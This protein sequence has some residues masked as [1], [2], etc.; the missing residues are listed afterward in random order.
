MTVERTPSETLP[1]PN[2]G[3]AAQPEAKSAA[4]A[5][6]PVLRHR[7]RVVLGW[8][9][10][11]LSG[12][13]V[14]SWLL[15]PA[16]WNI[17]SSHAVV[18]ARIM[19]LHSPIEGTIEAPPPAVGKAVEAGSVLVEIHN[20]LV[21]NSR[22]EELKTEA[23]SLDERVAALKRQ[24]AVLGSLK[25]SLADS[26][27]RYQ[28]AA[29]RRLETQIAEAKSTAAAAEA[30]L[31]QRRYKKDQMTGLLGDKGATQAEVVTARL[32]AEAAQN[33]VDQANLT[34]R[35]LS[36]QLE[37]VRQGNYIGSGDG[38]NDVPYSMQRMHEVDIHQQ[39]IQAKIQEF[40]ARA[41]QVQK[42]LRIE[43]ERLERQG[44]CRLKAPLDGIVW[45]RPLA[46]GST[47][48]RQTP[49]LELLDASDI[50]VD[51]L[52]GEKYFG[53]IHP[54]DKVA[55]KLIGSHAEVAGTVRDVLGKVAL[56][57]DRT[58]AAEAPKLG[59][60]DIHVIVSF[61]EGPPRSDNFHPYHIGQ[62]VEVRFTSSAGF[63]RQLWDL[64]S[65]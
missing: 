52:V 39:E 49:V 20:P 46:G 29:V 3:I 12:W 61:D 60:H 10:L 14:L 64:V 36:D 37:A 19:I 33:K 6:G 43:S 54:G 56:A 16:L 55:I 9:L 65:P 62:P 27:R 11:L 41:N 2:N 63:L 40:A 45:R 59:K 26:T 15:S 8:V 4:P 30:F 42:Q 32:A 35:R 50:F 5:R 28:E 25:E 22:C 51:A 48:T 57:D 18:N 47:V 53:E 31:K 23:A 7:I 21:D 24:H 58:L 34:V 38:R 17:T 1:I 44:C 13:L